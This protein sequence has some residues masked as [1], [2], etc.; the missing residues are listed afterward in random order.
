MP[1]AFVTGANRGLGLEFVRQY[2]RDGWRIIAAC[3]EPAKAA[4]LRKIEGAISVHALDVTDGGQVSALA[5]SLAG[6]PIDLLI[7]N[8][9]IYVA[10]DGRPGHM[11][12]AAWEETLRVNTLAPFRVT[13][14]LLPNILAGERK[15][16]VSISSILASIGRNTDGG[17]YAYRSSKTALNA[18]MRSLAVDLK[19]KGV[20]VVVFSPGWVSTDM[21]GRGAPVTPPDSVAGMRKIIAGLRPKDSGK[22]F[23]YDGG[24]LPW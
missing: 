12:Y 14:A 22:F 6:E 8:A 7:N 13:E 9:G 23:F 11:D 3:R 1:T 2:A 18:V 21:G 17:S 19:G 24:E 5:K 16:V 20:T 15:L 10:R 4:E